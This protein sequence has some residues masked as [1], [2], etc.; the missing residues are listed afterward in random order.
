MNFTLI[1]GASKGI[2]RALA[3]EYSAN[4]HNLVLTGRNQ[5]ELDTLKQSILNVNPNLIVETFSIDL[6]DELAYLNIKE[7]CNSNDIVIDNLV[8]NAGLASF[9]EFSKL[10]INIQLE[11][12]NV[13]I[14]A[15]VSL[16][17]RKSVV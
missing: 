3:I 4:Q 14:K 12:I 17:D 6:N 1:T 5:A 8:N 7:F 13:N 2:G 9:G 10:D 15:L 11:M 16:T